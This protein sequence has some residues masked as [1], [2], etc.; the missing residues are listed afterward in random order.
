MV[1]IYAG[2]K[3]I[4]FRKTMRFENV[5]QVAK[6]WNVE[7][8]E[9]DN[10]EADLRSVE[11]VNACVARYYQSLGLDEKGRALGSEEG[12]QGEPTHSPLFRTVRK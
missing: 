11:R 5:L 1:I 10:I 8:V 2:I 9:G 4:V 7:L 3:R 12:G 6:W